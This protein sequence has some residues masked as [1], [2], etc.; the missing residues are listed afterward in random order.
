MYKY[1]ESFQDLNN[2]EASMDADKRQTIKE[3]ISYLKLIR[4]SERPIS[5]ALIS[6]GKYEA[7]IIDPLKKI[8]AWSEKDDKNIEILSMKIKEWS[9]EKNPQRQ[10]DKMKEIM[11]SHITTKIM[12]NKSFLGIFMTLS[13]EQEDLL[14]IKK[15][16]YYF[17]LIKTLRHGL[18]ENFLL[19]DTT[20]R[21]AIGPLKDLCDWNDGD[22]KSI[23]DVAMAL[24]QKAGG[25]TLKEQSD[26][27][28][29]ILKTG[30]KIALGVGIAGL[31]IGGIFYLLKKNG[32]DKNGDSLKETEKTEE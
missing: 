25:K 7:R 23:K 22:D 17:L 26:G 12:K 8:S 30:G 14:R 28:K 18:F 6:E 16:A 4:M 3:V 24:S 13:P 19:G 21:K 5:N 20:K 31:A 32:K 15:T 11:E 27:I 1:T 9:D 2:K 10:I 29:N